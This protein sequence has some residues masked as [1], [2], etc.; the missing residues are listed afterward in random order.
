MNARVRPPGVY[1]TGLV[2][3]SHNSILQLIS[4]I[5]HR[6]PRGDSRWVQTLEE[7]E[8][9][10][11]AAGEM[12]HDLTTAVKQGRRLPDRRAR[13]R[14]LA[15]RYGQRRD[16]RTPPPPK[17]EVF[18]EVVRV[19]DLVAPSSGRTLVLPG[20]VHHHP[21]HLEEIVRARPG[22]AP[23]GYLYI[24]TDASGQIFIYPLQVDRDGSC[25]PGQSLL[26]ALLFPDR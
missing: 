21:S 2:A 20:A 24:Q 3:T 16:S 17:Y 26:G 12:V 1:V 19:A 18:D 15:R 13:G 9:H 5:I 23:D 14:I 10:F 7:L 8:D 6:R 25:H 4:A 11:T 22:L